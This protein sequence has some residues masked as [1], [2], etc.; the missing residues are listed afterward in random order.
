MNVV[1][2]VI[3]GILVIGF[4]WG[5]A[6]GFW[7]ILIELVGVYIAIIL[8]FKIAGMLNIQPPTNYIV[9]AIIFLV[10]L[11]IM[12]TIAKYIG[13]VLPMFPFS[14]ILGGIFGILVGILFAYFVLLFTYS[15]F[16][17]SHP[18]IQESP[19]ADIVN[20]IGAPMFAFVKSK[21]GG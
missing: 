15:Y 5:I 6:R 21:L 17:A 14:R 13:R 1:D 8:T 4:F 12:L 2:W 10:L 9:T 7:R 20:K 16:D 3:L 11:G 18:Y 19:F